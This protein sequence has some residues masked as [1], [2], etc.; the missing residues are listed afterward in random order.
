MAFLAAQVSVITATQPVASVALI[1]PLRL[2]CSGAGP[3]PSAGNTDPQ[4]LAAFVQRAGAK[5]LTEVN[6]PPHT[7]LPP[8]CAY[9]GHEADDRARCRRRQCV[10][11]NRLWVDR[12]RDW[13]DHRRIDPGDMPGWYVVPLHTTTTYRGSSS[14]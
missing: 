12:Q 5:Q 7:C 13:D 9:A 4:L 14:Q 2:R 10:D 11:M 3:A 8:T 1:G 6:Q